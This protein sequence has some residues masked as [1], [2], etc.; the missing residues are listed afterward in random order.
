MRVLIISRNTY[1]LNGPRPF[2]TQELSEELARQGHDVTLYTVHGDID[3]A[4]YEKETGVKMRDIKTFLPIKAN[5]NI[6]RYNLFYRFIWHCFY[7]FTLFPDIEFTYIVSSII[8]KEPKVD[9]LITIAMPHAIHMGAARA[10]KKLSRLFPKTWVADCGDPLYLNPY[11]KCP[12]YMAKWERRWCEA[13][14]YI[15]VPTEGSKDGYF[16]EY[17]GKIR[18]IPQGFNFC[19]TPIAKYRKN[20]IPTFVYCGSIYPGKRDVRSF[21]NFLLKW[22]KPYK[23]KLMMPTPLEG[24]FETESNGKI[25]YV[26]GKGR[27]EVIMEC[28]KADFLIN[29]KNPNST[30]TPSKLID[31]GI[32]GRP[33]LDISNDFSEQE[34]FEEFYRGDY[35]S[36]LILPNLEIYKIENVAKQFLELA[37]A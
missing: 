27:K 10:K 33:V 23:F 8:R 30:Q 20:D 34:Q 18:V 9:L 1:P 22:N 28:S 32:S 37:N 5:D 17:R 12:P 31:Y 3:Y 13:C 29:V 14:D 19:K 21:M 6:N 11:E 16:P 15:T 35:H 2:R 26:I 36:Q 7:R 4:N 24:K 25:E